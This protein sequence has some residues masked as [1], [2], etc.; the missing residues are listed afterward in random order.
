MPR[1]RFS[2]ELIRELSALC[3][4]TPE[5]GTRSASIARLEPG[6]VAELLYAPGPPCRT[7]LASAANLLG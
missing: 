4:H 6:R 7:E 1:S 2:P 3:I 5:Y